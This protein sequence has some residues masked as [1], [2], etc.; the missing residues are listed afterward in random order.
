VPT[1]APTQG[2]TTNTIN[3]WT[4]VQEHDV[5]DYVLNSPP[6][7]LLV[8]NFIK[9][10]YSSTDSITGTILNIAGSTLTLRVK[11]VQSAGYSRTNELYSNASVSKDSIPTKNSN[12]QTI[13]ANSFVWDITLNYSQSIQV[14]GNGSTVSATLEATPS[15]TATTTTWVFSPG[16]YDFNGQLGFTTGKS[17][18]FPVETQFQV[19][20]NKFGTSPVIYANGSGIGSNIYAGKVRGYTLSYNVGTISVIQTL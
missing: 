14:N 13:P 12:G 10:T 4:L 7:D 20:Y 11:N 5:L 15:L 9:I 19:S 8:G 18:L 3:D 17:I 16:F 6:S 2:V 1:P